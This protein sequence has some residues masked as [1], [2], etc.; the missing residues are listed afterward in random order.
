M[1]RSSACS[2]KEAVFVYHNCKGTLYFTVMLYT[3]PVPAFN[4]GFDRLGWKQ[5]RI[6]LQNDNN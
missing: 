3:T 6:S 1:Q 2:F 5:I 4:I